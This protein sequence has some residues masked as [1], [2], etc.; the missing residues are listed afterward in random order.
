MLSC[1][2]ASVGHLAQVA[3][4][5]QVLDVQVIAAVGA[6]D[7]RA[8][9]C[10]HRGKVPAQKPRR[11]KDGGCDAADLQQVRMSDIRLGGFS[12]GSAYMLQYSK[13]RTDER[14]PGPARIPTLVSD[15]PMCATSVCKSVAYCL[16]LQPLPFAAAPANTTAH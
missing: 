5:A 7:L 3:H 2:S 15:V 8:T 12:S 9:L 1:Q 10:Q 4:D 16:L 14:P 13:C 11:T 6:H